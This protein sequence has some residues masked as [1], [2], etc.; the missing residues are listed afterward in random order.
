MRSPGYISETKRLYS[1]IEIRLQDRDFLAGPGR[2]KYSI[3]DINVLPWIRIHGFAGI[4]SLDEWPNL[5][6]WTP[7]CRSRDASA[8]CDGL[9]GLVRD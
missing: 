7:C 8:D 1:V 6:V 2:G 4:E 5:K 3:A 9:S